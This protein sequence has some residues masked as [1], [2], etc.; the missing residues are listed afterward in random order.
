MLADQKETLLEGVV[1]EIGGAIID[2]GGVNEV[3]RTKV[4][5]RGNEEQ[6]VKTVA[7]D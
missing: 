4:A 2:V 3:D 5:N 1:S 6:Q 7:P